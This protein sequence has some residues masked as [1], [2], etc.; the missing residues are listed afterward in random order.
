MQRKT[1]A[2]RKRKKLAVNDD[3]VPPCSNGLDDLADVVDFGD[4]EMGVGRSFERE[5]DGGRS[6]KGGSLVD[7]LSGGRRSSAG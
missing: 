1:R 5:D 7:G 2:R 6:A 3:P 4:W